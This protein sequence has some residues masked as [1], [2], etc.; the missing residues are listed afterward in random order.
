MENR[1]GI[2]CAAKTARIWGTVVVFVACDGD[3]ARG[4]NPRTRFTWAR[5]S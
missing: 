5:T 2:V 4:G 3:V 1:V